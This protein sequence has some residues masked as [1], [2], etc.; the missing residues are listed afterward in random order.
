MSSY[1]IGIG[2]FEKRTFPTL[3]KYLDRALY[4]TTVK[5][6][7]NQLSKGAAELESYTLHSCTLWQVP[8]S[9]QFYTPHRSTLC[10]V[11]QSAGF[12]TAQFNT[13][14]STTICTVLHT[15]QFVNSRF[16]SV[17][18]CGYLPPTGTSTTTERSGPSDSLVR[19]THKNGSASTKCFKDIRPKYVFQLNVVY[20]NNYY[21]RLAL[22]TQSRRGRLRAN[23]TLRFYTFHKYIMFK[24]ADVQYQVYNRKK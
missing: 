23:E 10:T 13:L 6:T 14:H 11:P 21:P 5:F 16:T 22:L 24:E 7:L 4:W 12:Y 8:H 1:T 18:H 9:A 3:H 20:L 15:A 17:I 19:T 2:L